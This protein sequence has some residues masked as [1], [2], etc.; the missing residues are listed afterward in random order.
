MLHVGKS[1]PPSQFAMSGKNIIVLNALTPTGFGILFFV[2]HT[3][4]SY[5][6]K[7]AQI[8]AKKCGALFVFVRFAVFFG[9]IWGFLDTISAFFW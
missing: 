2:K 5:Q 1:T 8:L 6:T 4:N 7:S 3:F 9:K